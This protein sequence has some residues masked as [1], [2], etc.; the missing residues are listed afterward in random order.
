MLSEASQNQKGK[1]YTV[2]LMQNK[3]NIK[4]TE[5]VEKWL[6]RVGGNKRM[7]AK[8]YKLSVIR[9]EDLTKNIATIADNTTV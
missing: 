8:G 3:E 4:L 2:L 6:L 5:T 7:L 1:H 9:S